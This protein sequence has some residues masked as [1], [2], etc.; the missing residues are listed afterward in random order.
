MPSLVNTM[1]I[2]WKELNMVE[3]NTFNSFWLTWKLASFVMET[4]M[5]RIVSWLPMYSL[6]WV[7]H[8]RW[9][10]MGS[11]GCVHTHKRRLAIEGCDSPRCVWNVVEKIRENN[12]KVGKIGWT[13]S[14]TPTLGPKHDTLR[15]CWKG[16]GLL[17]TH[18]RAS[19]RKGH[20]STMNLATM[21]ETTWPNFQN[22]LLG[23][24]V[25]IGM[26]SM[27]PKI[28]GENVYLQIKDLSEL[29]KDLSWAQKQPI[30][31]DFLTKTKTK[32]A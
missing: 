31:Q 25:V 8:K 12:W 28:I 7:Q 3:R 17:L 13:I 22:R 15:C 6:P 5:S 19:R 18:V 27:S 10:P 32:Q 14:Q 11:M 30:L 16:K 1:L 2:C 20:W 21:I 23:A 29:S 26:S 9:I 24:K 4:K